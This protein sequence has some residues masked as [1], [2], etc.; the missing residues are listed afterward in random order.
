MRNLV[1]TIAL[2]V[3]LVGN[4]QDRKAEPSSLCVR[5]QLRRQK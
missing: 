5:L 3:S 2:L 1:G 4:T